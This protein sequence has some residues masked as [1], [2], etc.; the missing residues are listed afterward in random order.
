MLGKNLLHQFTYFAISLSVKTTDVSFP[1]GQFKIEGFNTP[2]N[3]DR[4]ISGGGIMLYAS[5]DISAKLLTT[6]KLLIECFYIELNLRSK[7]G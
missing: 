1:M 5:E 6:E 4:D 3:L 7:N 2:C